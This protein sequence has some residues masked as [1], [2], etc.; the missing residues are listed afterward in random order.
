MRLNEDPV[1]PYLKEVK[2]T[3]EL[4]IERKPYWGILNLSMN[5]TSIVGINFLS[6]IR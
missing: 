3:S 2:R 4:P 1:L 6:D 5:V